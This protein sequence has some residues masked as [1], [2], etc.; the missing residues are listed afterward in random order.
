MI[1][2][3]REKPEQAIFALGDLALGFGLKTMSLLNLKG[4]FATR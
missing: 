1:F 3:V 4:K 2:R